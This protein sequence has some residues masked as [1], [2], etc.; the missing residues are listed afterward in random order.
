[1]YFTTVE[2]KNKNQKATRRGRDLPCL[3]MSERKQ[4]SPVSWGVWIGVDTSIP[5]AIPFFLTFAGRIYCEGCVEGRKPGRESSYGVCQ[6]T[7]AP[8][9]SLSQPRTGIEFIPCLSLLGVVLSQVE[10]LTA[11]WVVLRSP[12][13]PRRPDPCQD[14]TL[15]GGGWGFWRLEKVM[16]G[17][18][19]L[20]PLWSLAM[21]QGEPHPLPPR[22]KTCKIGA[23]PCWNL[24]GLAAQAPTVLVRLTSSPTVP[25]RRHHCVPILQM[26]TLSAIGSATA[27]VPGPTGRGPGFNPEAGGGESRLSTGSPM[28]PRTPGPW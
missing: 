24:T 16:G 3:W 27:N 11:E 9:P 6:A 18:T 4:A 15:A 7:P 22:I 17:G 8:G 26:E 5:M 1:M 25:P 28:L 19:F 21:M 14:T 2:N 23:R 13:T 12:V 10:F 20:P